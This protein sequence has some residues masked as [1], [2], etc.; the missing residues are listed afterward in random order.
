MDLMV[1]RGLT[2]AEDDDD[3]AVRDYQSFHQLQGAC[4]KIII[5]NPDEPAFRI[6]GEN[7]FDHTDAVT[8][9]SLGWLE[10]ITL[11]DLTK[12][13]GNLRSYVDL[14]KIVGPRAVD[15]QRMQQHSQL[16]AMAGEP[17]GGQLM[18]ALRTYYLSMSS[19]HPAFL[20]RRLP[21]FLTDTSWPFPYDIDEA[22]FMSAAFD[23]TPR[24]QWAKA[25]RNEWPSLVQG[26][27]GG[28]VDRL[29]PLSLAVKDFI[30]QPPVLIRV[31]Q[32]LGDELLP[33]PGENSSKLVFAHLDGLNRRL[34]DDFTGLIE[35]R[36]AAGVG[37]EDIIQHLITLA[38]APLGVEKE[39]VPSAGEVSS[40]GIASLA[41]R[42]D[43]IQKALA[44][45]S[46]QRL[47]QRFADILE[48]EGQPR[49][50][51]LELL[52]ECFKARS[53]LPKAVLLHAKGM[54]VAVYTRQSHFL[55]RL[56]DER[57]SLRL[58]LGQCMAYDESLEEVPERLR[59]WE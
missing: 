12:R 42:T 19:M 3:Q 26:R 20:A 1:D 11:G 45:A 9:P 52:S 5:S 58:Y 39:G 23:L 48:E 33:G 22:D 53:V 18:L 15:D 30:N 7:A 57:V 13:S 10:S 35:E 38:S 31:I 25:G 55:A 34:T 40:D 4:D 29:Y 16:R 47:E 43:Q 24:C 14:A 21:D 41:P 49:K 8:D 6:E 28:A 46:Y 54:R 36:S 59:T 51:V 37:S 50:D 32:G 27:L 2:D 44:E 56:V 17:G